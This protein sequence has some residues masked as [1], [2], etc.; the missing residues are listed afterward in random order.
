MKIQV[1][2]LHMNVEESGSGQPL[3][4]VHGFPLDHT[5]WK[6]T[7]QH[8]SPY[9]RVITPDLRGHGASDAPEGIYHMDLLA[10][11]LLGLFDALHLEKAILAGQSMGGYVSLAFACAHPERLSGLGLIVTQAAADAPERR[12]GR[13]AQAQQVLTEGVASL[14]ESMTPK[15]AVSST[16]RLATRRVMLKT[17]PAGVAGAL[18]GMAERPD[19]T[20][21][22][23]ELRM[24]ALVIAGGADPIIPLERAQEMAALLPDA[25]LKVIPGVG[26]MPMLEAPAALARAFIA[27]FA[28]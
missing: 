27:R 18:Q 14:V 19:R 24:P 5:I 28:K 17:S 20:A 10:Q 9:F 11:D 6:K 12:A 2:G 26:H 4:L 16:A 1:N 22:L 13:Y 8:L 7:A 25:V 3:V 23:A 21:S 15:M